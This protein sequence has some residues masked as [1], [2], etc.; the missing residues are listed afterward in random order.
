V[1]VRG[2]GWREAGADAGLGLGALALYVATV[3]PGLYT[4][5]SA[6]LAAGAHVLGIVH[7]TGYPVYLLLAKGFSLALP[8]GDPAYRANLFSAVCAAASLP[9]LRRAI[10]TATGDASAALGATAALAVAYP[11]WSQAVRAEVYSLHALFL[12]LALW[13]ALGWRSGGGDGRLVA[14]GIT[15]GLSL[16]NHMTTVLMLPGLAVLLAPALR[17]RRVSP[18]ALTLAALGLALGPASYLYLP[19]R[20]AA[21]PAVDYAAM[22]EVDLSTLSG[23]LWMARGAMFAGSMFAYSLAEAPAQA[24]RLFMLVWD[25]L[26]G[27]GLLVAALGAWAEWRRD[28]GLALGLGLGAA[29]T[30]VFF[31]GYRVPDKDTMFLPLFMVLAVWLAEGLT[32][33]RAGWPAGAFL[34]PE[35]VL[36]AGVTALVLALAIVNYPRVDLRGHTDTRAF[37]E[38]VMGEVA[39]DAFV[40]GAWVR[41]TPLLYLQA[42]EGQRPDVELFDWGLYS[43]GR[44]ARLRSAGVA[45]A[46]ARDV[47]ADELLGIVERELLAG[48]PVY[49]LEDN[50][51]LRERFDLIRGRRVMRVC[52][53]GS[54]G[55]GAC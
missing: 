28:R 24:L 1:G 52:P 30:A 50:L 37:A 44:R 35:R 21:H 41:I 43:L 7:A 11:F 26:L 3:A 10:V 53:P 13:L 34:R 19:L 27:V 15:L 25:S 54:A 40:M 12:A 16:G 39:P 33:L 45:D 48:R 8:L 36:G 5:D 55:D 29:A 47:A 42:V 38:G 18:C 20:H 31:A 22:L 14:L 4:L 9:P 49:S 17:R 46:T 23:V 32:A 6:E 51:V 2:E